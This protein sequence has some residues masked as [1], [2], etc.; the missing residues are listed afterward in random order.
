MIEQVRDYSFNG[1]D[2]VVVHGRRRA[3]RHSSNHH[4]GEAFFDERVDQPVSNERSSSLDALEMRRTWYFSLVAYAVMP[5]MISGKNGIDMA[6]RGER[7]MTRPM[8]FDLR[9]TR[10]RAMALG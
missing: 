2:V 1:G 9:C 4:K 3:F 8:R 7:D 5:P 10:L 6:T